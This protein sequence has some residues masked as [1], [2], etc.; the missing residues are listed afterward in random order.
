[1]KYEVPTGVLL[2]VYIFTDGTNYTQWSKVLPEKLTVPQL[3]KKLPT[4]YGT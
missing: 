4:L 1:V 3:V 2:R